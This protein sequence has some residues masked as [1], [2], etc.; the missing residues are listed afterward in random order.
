MKILTPEIQKHI[1]NLVVSSAIYTLNNTG[2]IELA[3]EAL[4]RLDRLYEMGIDYP[5]F[6]LGC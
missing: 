4:A 1:D 6:F 3:D 5:S 2:P